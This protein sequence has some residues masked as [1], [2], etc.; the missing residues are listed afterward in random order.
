MLI[1]TFN[2]KDVNGKESSR[3]LLPSSV[4]TEMYSGTDM[5]ELS[6][7]DQVAYVSEV[8]VLHEA[9]L[10]ARKQLDLDYDLKHRIR[11]F[12]KDNITNL[13]LEDI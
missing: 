10:A 1:Y 7:E 5:S 4:P 9:Y 8:D 11:Q 13:V 6:A 3:V 12:K 2:Y